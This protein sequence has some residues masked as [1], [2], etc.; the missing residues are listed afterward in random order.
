[1]KTTLT[2]RC[3]KNAP[4]TGSILPISFHLKRACQIQTY[5]KKEKRP[6][7]AKAYE[8]IRLNTFNRR[9]RI[10]NGISAQQTKQELEVERCSEVTAIQD[11][12]QYL[13]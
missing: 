7:K 2:P 1:M 6:P 8:L 11:F 10:E 3:S 12:R 13:G 4:L 5:Q 9:V